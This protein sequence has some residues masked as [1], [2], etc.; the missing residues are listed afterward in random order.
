MVQL[1]MSKQRLKIHNKTI[2]L[3]SE[4][5][6]LTVE[7]DKEN[8]P[9]PRPLS[10]STVHLYKEM[11]YK[12]VAEWPAELA[13]TTHP[14]FCKCETVLEEGVTVCKTSYKAAP[15][16]LVRPATVWV[17]FGAPVVRKVYMWKCVNN[18]T[19]CNIYYD[20]KG[21]GIFNYSNTTMVAHS[22][23]MEFLFG[24]ASG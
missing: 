10:S 2:M 3:A 12:P 21:D 16:A 6:P 9:L 23:L 7:P 4:I 15:Q 24:L 20:G 18:N 5:Q 13:P 8:S 14:K 1:E 22:V 19:P 17:P 11:H